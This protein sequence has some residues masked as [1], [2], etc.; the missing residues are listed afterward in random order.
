MDS[1]RCFHAGNKNST[2]FISYYGT[3][4]YRMGCCLIMEMTDFSETL[5]FST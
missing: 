5:S 3:L 4:M 1:V 2:E